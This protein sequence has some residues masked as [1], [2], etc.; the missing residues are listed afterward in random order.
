MKRE[1]IIEQLKTRG[2]VYGNKNVVQGIYAN[3]KLSRYAVCVNTYIDEHL[4]PMPVE[5]YPVEEIEGAVDRFIEFEALA[6]INMKKLFGKIVELC[7][8]GK[9][10]GFGAD[11]GENTLTIEMD[12]KHSH[13]GVPQGSIEFLIKNLY[14][15]LVEGK[16]LTWA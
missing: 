10:I 13:I 1:E 9:T 6:S 7:N 4:A 16:G 14:E 3:N 8:A 5:Y 15:L 11:M 12:G 2:I